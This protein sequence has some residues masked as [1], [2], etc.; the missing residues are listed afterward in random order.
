[1]K[2]HGFG[3]DGSQ[4]N[5]GNDQ[6]NGFQS[7]RFALLLLML[8]STQS[9]PDIRASASSFDTGESGP[10]FDIIML[11]TN[12]GSSELL[13]GF[14]ESSAMAPVSLESLS[15]LVS[16]GI[17]SSESIRSL[18]FVSIGSIFGSS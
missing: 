18:V 14:S 12:V 1:M 16:K 5:D 15:A 10:D 8:L 4:G 9:L 2:G 7:K 17:W 6:W 11:W 13:S 3:T